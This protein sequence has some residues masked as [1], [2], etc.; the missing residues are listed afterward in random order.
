MTATPRTNAAIRYAGDGFDTYGR[1]REATA[2]ADLKTCRR[3]ENDLTEA[4]TERDA[5][6]AQIHD[7]CHDLHVPGPVTPA[8]FC[9]GC[10]AFQIKLFGESP[11]VA[12][13]EAQSQL[14][15]SLRFLISTLETIDS[16]ER[17]AARYEGRLARVHTET[18]NEARA[19]LKNHGV[20]N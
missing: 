9:N 15:Y 13:R 18:L 10:E 4:C 20:V 17:F 7:L 2:Y 8:E 11:I 12:L 3:L 1:A 14:S 5:L 19:V 6:R 16:D